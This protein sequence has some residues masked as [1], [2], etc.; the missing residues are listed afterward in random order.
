MDGWVDDGWM[1]NECI[2]AW[3]G[4]WVGRWVDGCMEWVG[5]WM[6]RWMATDGRWRIDG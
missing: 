5:G 4:G 2:H 3:M 1:I 6:H